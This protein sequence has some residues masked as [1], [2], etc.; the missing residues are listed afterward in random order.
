MSSHLNEEINDREKSDQN[1]GIR[2]AVTTDDDRAEDPKC[3]S[4][5]DVHNKREGVVDGINVRWKPVDYSSDWSYIEEPDWSLRRTQA[6][7]LSQVG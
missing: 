4:E 1:G 2:E 6:W 5:Q 3:L 7:I